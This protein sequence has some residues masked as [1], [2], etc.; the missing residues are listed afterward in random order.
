[1]DDVTAE[2]SRRKARVEQAQRNRVKA[3]HDRDVAQAAVLQAVSALREEFDVLPEGVPALEKQLES[4]LAAGLA[5]ADR[6]LA[7]AGL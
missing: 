5:E 1:M 4:Q 7:E 6:A 2:I 3:E